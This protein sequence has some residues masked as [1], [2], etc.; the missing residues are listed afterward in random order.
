MAIRH[1]VSLRGAA[2]AISQR[3][4]ALLGMTLRLAQG[5]P[6]RSDCGACPEPWVASV[7]P[8]PRNDRRGVP[9]LAM[10]R[11]FRSND[12]SYLCSWD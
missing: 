8:L 7:A 3:F 1:A 6:F 5:R 10:T 12:D 4:L 2:E 9:L 11:E